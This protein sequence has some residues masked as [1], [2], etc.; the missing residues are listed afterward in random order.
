M[1]ISRDLSAY[2]DLIRFIAALAVMLGHMDQDGIPMDWLPLA[3]F[4]H[5]AVI[6]FF[7][8]S[9][10]IIYNN[11]RANGISAATYAIARIS[12]IYSVALPAIVFSVL[13]ALF[14]QGWAEPARPSHYRPVLWPEILSSLLFLNES[15]T[16]PAILTLNDPYWSLCYEVWFYVM[17]GAFVFTRGVL[18]WLLL[19]VSA[20]TAGPA[21]LVLLP[22]WVL[23]AWAAVRL[24]SRPRWSAPTAWA[25]FALAPVLLVAVNVTEADILLRNWLKEGVPSLWRLRGS[26]RFLTD[27][28]LGFALAVHLLAFASLPAGLRNWIAERQQLF[29]KLAGFSFTLYL[30]HRPLTQIVG[31]YFSEFG[32]TV[33]GSAAIALAIL[34]FCWAVSFAT[35]RQLPHWR[36]AVRALFT[37]AGLARAKPQS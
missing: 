19:A 32:Q 18:R 30:F 15:W 9:G 33:P 36:R 1:K 37:Q 20:L 12:R 14:I 29:A 23:G 8:L 34:L 26:Q 5:E 11:T 2:L 16:N 35:E 27:Y 31:T 25:L 10:F 13:A 28:L 6:V 24:D 4:A 3:H 7:V 22:I 21:I 17:F